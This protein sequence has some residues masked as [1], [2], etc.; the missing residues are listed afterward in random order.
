MDNLPEGASI[1]LQDGLE[2]T[3]SVDPH[4]AQS[5]R[6]D[7]HALVAVGWGGAQAKRLVS[8]ACRH[9]TASHESVTLGQ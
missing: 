8:S 2:R 1:G 6:A 7:D 9:L 3:I 5:A 4:V